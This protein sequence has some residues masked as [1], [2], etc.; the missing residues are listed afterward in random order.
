LQPKRGRAFLIKRTGFLDKC[1]T[2]KS[3][4]GVVLI[5]AA[6][7][8]MI[9]IIRLVGEIRLQRFLNFILFFKR[10]KPELDLVSEA[11]APENRI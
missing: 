10:T 11:L 5:A 9:L 1:H 8:G 2:L 4:A 3:C 7:A 6:A